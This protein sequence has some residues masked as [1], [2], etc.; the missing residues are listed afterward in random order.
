[1]IHLR[2]IL[3]RITVRLN[4]TLVL[5]TTIRQNLGDGGPVVTHK[6]FGK[7]HSSHL[8]SLPAWGSLE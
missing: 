7:C 6:T 2:E 1:M 3:S 4:D 5:G 8:L